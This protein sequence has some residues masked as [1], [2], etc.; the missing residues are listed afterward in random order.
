MGSFVQQPTGV[1]P[2]VCSLDCPDQCGLLVHKKDGKIV[3][4]QGDPSHPV[5]KGHICNKVR[6]MMERIYDPKRLK[7][8]L[9]RIGAKGEGKF[10]RISWDEALETIAA[11]WKELIETYGPESI[12]PY[13]FYGNMGRLSAEGMDRR[14]FHRLGASLLDRTICSSAGSQGLQ[15]TMGGG[16]GIDPEETIHAKLVIFWGINA[17]STNMHQVILAQKAR[18]NGAKI[19]VI[20]VHKNQTGQ[21]A[22]WFIPILPGTDAALALG[23]MHILFAENLIDDEFLRKYTVGYEELREHVVQYDPV[24]VSNITGVPVEDLYTLARWYGQT[25]PSFIRIGNGLQHHDNGGMC[26]RTI[27]CLPALT[28]QW[29]VKGGGAIKSNSGYLALNQ[30]SLQRPDLLQNKH[31]RIINMNRLGEALLELDPPIRSLFVYGTNPAVVAPNSNKVRQGLAR[32]DLFVIVH[33]LFVTET[34]KYADIVLPATS[35]FENTDLYTSYWHHYVQIQQPVIER[36]G[37]SKSNVEVFQLLAKRMG[38]EDPCLYETEE[39]MIS[40]AL[41]NPTNPFLEGIRYET[42]VEKQY[43]KAK[44]KRLLPGTLPTPS[45]KIEL[46]SKK[47]EQDGY[48]PLPTYT[49]IVDDGDFPFFFVPGPNHNFLNTTFSNNEKHIS[50]EKEPRLYMNVK[51]ALAKGIQDGDRV[52]VWNDRGECVLKASVGEHVLPGVVVTQ[53]LWADSP[54]TK[55]LVNSLTP[56]R[57]ADMGGG[58]TFFSG[59]VDVEKC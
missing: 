40:Q 30:I 53:G 5:T 29:L 47:M 16:F 32:E 36:Y 34:A 23:M 6:N 49:P 3:K 21:L 52:R 41:D 44:V 33:D 42:L 4:I 7:Y 38:F 37:E 50:L 26:I 39:E 35:S 58:A 17:V 51:D 14:F 1:F 22:D 12:L 18:K 56:D 24:T 46:Y 13:S 11:K 31:T 8:P 28:G 2:S 54:D 43:I 15:Y 27:A 20:D 19:V 57:I 48:P 10:A 59:R 45:G 25:T 55:H 9:K